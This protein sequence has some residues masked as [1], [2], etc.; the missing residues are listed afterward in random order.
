[1]TTL[2]ANIEALKTLIEN[3]QGI[4][5]LTVTGDCGTQINLQ[6]KWHKFTYNFEPYLIEI[7]FDFGLKIEIFEEDIVKVNKCHQDYR[8]CLT[9]GNDYIGNIFIDLLPKRS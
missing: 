8:H 3:A 9:L 1:M 6:N 5:F 4:Q 7:T 2:Q